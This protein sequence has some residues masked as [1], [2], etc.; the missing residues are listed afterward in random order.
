[1]DQTLKRIS[2]MLREDQYEKLSK[3]DLNLSGLI[4]DLID[5]HLSEY[6][7]TLTVS[8][9]TRKLYDQI[10]SNTGTQ[11]SELEPFLRAALHGMLKDKIQAMQKLEQNAFKR[12]AK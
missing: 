6:K 11:D 4:R 1:M 7:I 2:L 10:I 3:E 5:D 9:E 12:G 8:E